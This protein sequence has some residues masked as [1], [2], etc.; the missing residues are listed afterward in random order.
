M[1]GHLRAVTRR[2]LGTTMIA[3]ALA[4][5]GPGRAADPIKI[6]VIAGVLGVGVGALVARLDPA[7]RAARRG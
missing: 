7:G 5:G 3:G 4:A 2:A 1:A 6:G